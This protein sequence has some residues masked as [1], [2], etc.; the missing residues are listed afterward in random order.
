VSPDAE[1]GLA[2]TAVATLLLLLAGFLALRR[3]GT[4]GPE[5]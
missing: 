5:E 2:L 3:I 4:F 1:F